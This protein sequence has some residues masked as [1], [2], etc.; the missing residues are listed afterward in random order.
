MDL[1]IGESQFS[2]CTALRSSSALALNSARLLSSLCRALPL[3]A[4]AL[5]RARGPCRRPSV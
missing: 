3:L 5:P 1:L 2:D 4:P